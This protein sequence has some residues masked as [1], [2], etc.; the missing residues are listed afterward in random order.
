[1]TLAIFGKLASLQIDALRIIG[2]EQMKESKVYDQIMEEG[3]VESR[4][5]D[6]LAAVEIRF[7]LSAAKEFAPALNTFADRSRL[8]RVHRLAPR[9]STQEQFRD[10]FPQSA[11][12]P[13]QKR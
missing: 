10:R 12:R 5:E 2:R 9:Y 3:R 11:K 4:R 6:I 1:L 8:A 7:G 13:Q